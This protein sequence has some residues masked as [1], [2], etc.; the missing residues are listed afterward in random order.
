MEKVPLSLV[1]IGLHISARLPQY[2]LFITHSELQAVLDSHAD[3]FKDELGIVK[4]TSISLVMK[5]GTVPKF[6]RLCPVP[7]AL[8]DTIS[9]ELDRL[10]KPRYS[11][12]D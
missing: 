7:L 4:G 11:G 5:D 9:K 3:V 10:Q 2:C 1:A 8:K 12:E 6:F